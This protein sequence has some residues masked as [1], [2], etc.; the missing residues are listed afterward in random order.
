MEEGMCP[1]REAP[2]TTPCT[3]EGPDEGRTRWLRFRLT[4][5][6][7]SMCRACVRPELLAEGS[8]KP[9]NLPCK[10]G[11]RRTQLLHALTTSSGARPR[12]VLSESSTSPSGHSSA[13]DCFVQQGSS[14]NTGARRQRCSPGRADADSPQP[15][16]MAYTGHSGLPR[17]KHTVD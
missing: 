2:V 12:P 17:G 15:L 7:S 9:L 4:E 8:G 11:L 10:T 16:P 13:T 6:M 3:P 1:N 5:A 14:E